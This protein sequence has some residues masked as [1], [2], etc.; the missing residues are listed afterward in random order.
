[1]LSFKACIT[2]ALLASLVAGC[3]HAP[4]PASAAVSPDMPM[5]L[6]TYDPAQLS[7]AIF[8]ETNRV[9]VLHNERPLLPDPRLD[10]A[11]DIQ[12]TYMALALKAGHDNPEPGERNV[13][14]RVT[15]QNFAVTHVGENAIMMSAIKP[16]GSQPLNY[17]Y[18]EYASLL[19]EAWMNSPDHRRNLLSDRYA[20]LGCAARLSHA[21]RRGD[22]RIFAVQVFARSAVQGEG[23]ESL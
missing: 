11:A 13:A 2:V 21:F 6:D 5:V 16:D 9:R 20:D 15:H 18:R 22:Y 1:V 17:D 19:V 7:R 10:A 8:D 23:T 3:A 4:A 14:E 12:A